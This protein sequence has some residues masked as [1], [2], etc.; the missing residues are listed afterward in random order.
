MDNKIKG[1]SLTE[2]L[3]QEE[4][5][6]WWLTNVRPTCDICGKKTDRVLEYKISEEDDGIRVCF[7][8]ERSCSRDAM[9]LLFAQNPEIDFL[10]TRG[11]EFRKIGATR[12]GSVSIKR[13]PI[14]L[15]KRYAVMKK[16]GFQCVLC[17][18][19]GKEAKLEIDHIV[20]VSAGGGEEIKNL[21]TLCFNCNRGKKDS[22]E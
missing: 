14:G 12:G 2:A 19:S 8:S 20:P 15:S 21:R 11:I 16:D 10:W 13:E 22:T 17:G 9:N 3:W 18:S 1:D 6:A 5:N 7:I 4:P